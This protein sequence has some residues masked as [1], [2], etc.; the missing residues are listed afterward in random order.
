[1]RLVKKHLPILEHMH[2]KDQVVEVLIAKVTLHGFHIAIVNIYA[3][4]HATLSSIFNTITK[5]LCHFHQNEILLI[6]GDLNIDMSWCSEKTRELENYMCNY[7]AHLLLDK[8]NH[9][10]KALIDHI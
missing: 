5:L 1:M 10:Q 7:N 9:A 4:L 3:A 6:L 8:T 2:Y